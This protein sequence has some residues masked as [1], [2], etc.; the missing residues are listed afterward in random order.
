MVGRILLEQIIKNKQYILL[1]C[2][3]L[4]LLP[5]KAFQSDTIRDISGSLVSNSHIDSVMPSDANATSFNYIFI[6][7]TVHAQQNV[8]QDSLLSLIEI[9]YT[10]LSAWFNKMDKLKRQKSVSPT[11]DKFHRP[12]WLVVALVLILVGLALVRIFFSV[13]FLNVVYGYF[14]ERV[15]AQISKEDN[16][17]TSWP[18]IFLYIIFSFSLGL[19]VVIYVSAKE[20]LLFMTISNFTR[21]SLVIGGLFVAKLLLIR[22]ISVIFEAKRMARDYITVLYIVYFNTMLILIPILI[23]A[24]FLP[25]YYLD[26]L[27]V[28][29]GIGVLLIF[30]YRILRTALSLLGHLKFSIFYLIL[31]LC[32]LEIAP[33]LILVKSLNN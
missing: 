4:Y 6:D 28:I 5:I 7:T 32:A 8:L 25:F 27:A 18:Y 9:E 12:V 22:I 23:L 30:S 33:I 29:L 14:N 2:S 3:L 21:L 11:V 10:D 17:L 26:Y 31:Y 1:I 19:F 20:D 13:T 24:I 16:M 15:L